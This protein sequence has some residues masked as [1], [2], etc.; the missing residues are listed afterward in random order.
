MT[1]SSRGAR[2]VARFVPEGS[3]AAPATSPPP[4]RPVTP[5]K[6]FFR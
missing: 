1:T 4:D 3:T 2:L 6:E 5:R